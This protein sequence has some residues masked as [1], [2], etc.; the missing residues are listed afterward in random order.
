MDHGFAAG[1][2]TRQEDG[3]LH[4]SAGHREGPLDPL[5]GAAFDLER[6]A[7]GRP[8]ASQ[9]GAHG[10]ERAG[11]AVH[12]AHTQRIVADQAVPPG[13]RRHESSEEAHRGARVATVEIRGARPEQGAA[14]VDHDRASLGDGD[15]R[16]EGTQGP[17]GVGHVGAVGEPLDVGAALGEG[18]EDE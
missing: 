9:R 7:E 3:R 15:G 16:P 17:E 13:D 10:A 11:D 1:A 5:Q 2:E 8:P 12:G 4:L 18:A 6:R 14:S